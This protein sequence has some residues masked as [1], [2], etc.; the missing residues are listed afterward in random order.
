MVRFLVRLL[1][2]VIGV[3]LV[4]GVASALA[5]LSFKKKSPPLPDTAAD[6]I[7]LVAVM[8]GVKLASTAAAFRG[9]R[10]ISWYG[11]LDL[12]LREATFDPAGAQLEVR[13]AFGGTR[14]VVAPGVPV[15]ASGPT[16]FGGRTNETTGQAA[17]TDRPGLEITGFTVFGGLQIVEAERDEEIATW[18]P[19]RTPEAAAE[20]AADPPAEPAPAPA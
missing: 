3:S 1:G 5:A 18:V 8:D 15:T 2:L 17:D 4:A 7:D 11:G 16:V 10:L 20:P 14:V 6:Q 13:T 19:E 9:G 12:D